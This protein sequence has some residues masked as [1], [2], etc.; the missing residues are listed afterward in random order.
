[1]ERLVAVVRWTATAHD[2]S[3]RRCRGRLVGDWRLDNSSA[4]Y[5]LRGCPAGYTL[6]VRSTLLIGSAD[7]QEC[8]ASLAT[9]YILR[10][11]SD[12][13][14]TCLPGLKCNGTDVVA[15]ALANSTW[16]RNG[17]IYRLTAC[18]AGNSVSSV[19][20]SGGQHCSISDITVHFL[21]LTAMNFG[22]GLSLI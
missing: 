15:P 3:P 20:G 18:P 12:A 13:C 7:R 22:H 21:Y 6:R 10:P 11:D 19:G 8:Q 14:Q 16:Q 5:K 2:D 17:S 4:Q 1:M 9:E